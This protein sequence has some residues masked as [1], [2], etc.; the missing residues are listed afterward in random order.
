MFEK[1]IRC[2]RLGSALTRLRNLGLWTSIKIPRDLQQSPIQA[3][4]G[5]IDASELGF[6]PILPLRF[7]HWNPRRDH[8]IARPKTCEAKCGT[9]HCGTIKNRLLA[10]T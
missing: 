5:Q 7:R 1:S 10:T 3:A 6:G 9:L 4:V 2:L 8:F